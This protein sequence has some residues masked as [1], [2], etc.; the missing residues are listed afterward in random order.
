VGDGKRVKQGV[1]SEIAE[2]W[3]H[4]A[5][6]M[7]MPYLE[8][9]LAAGSHD[10]CD[11]TLSLAWQHVVYIWS[12]MA[13]VT[14]VHACTDFDSDNYVTTKSCVGL[15]SRATCSAAGHFTPQANVLSVLNSGEHTPDPSRV[16]HQDIDIARLH[17]YCKKKIMGSRYSLYF[18]TTLHSTSQIVKKEW[19]GE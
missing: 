11:P 19:G 14:C 4:K 3:L 15:C 5:Q 2:Q 10:N 17:M 6:W 12:R 8:S 16:L 18:T 1:E 7:T 13:V 9:P